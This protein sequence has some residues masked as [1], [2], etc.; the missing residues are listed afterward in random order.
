[1]IIPENWFEDWFNTS[2]YHLLYAHRSDVEAQVFM[3]AV[4]TFLNLKQGTLVL[5]LA[6]GKG[7]HSNYLAQKGMQ[8]IGMDLSEKNIDY[9]KLHAAPQAQFQ[10]GDM[11]HI[12]FENQF[13]LT[14][15]LFTSFGYFNEEEDNVA[16]FYEVFKALKKGGYF[17]FDY[18]NPPFVLKTLH[19]TSSVYKGEVHIQTKKELHGEWVQKNIQ[20]KDGNKSFIFHEKVHLLS[21]E[22]AK[23]KLEKAGFQMVEHWG[24]YNLNPFQAELSPRSIILAKVPD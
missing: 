7:R 8:V 2:Y 1:M 9:A 24:D 19:S 20:V 22:W 5:D 3:D 14:V 12:P 11:R 15:N 6:C 4:C 10:V 18:L 21:A 23:T 16:V 17:L 13:D